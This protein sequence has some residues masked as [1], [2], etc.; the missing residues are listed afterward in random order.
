M[1]R[2]IAF[3]AAIILA[4][5]VAVGQ[6]AAQEQAETAQPAPKIN[7]DY[8]RTN[9]FPKFYVPYSEPLVPQPSMSNSDRL[10]S[11]MANGKLRLSV[12]DVIALALENNLDIAV[13]RFGPAVAQTDVSRA[14]SGGATRGVSG[15]FTSSALF[16]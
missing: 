14:K 11:L 16:A 8:T 5:V 7:L 15:A 6:L 13:A 2:R 4:W 9:W 12:D 10:R 3:A 1:T